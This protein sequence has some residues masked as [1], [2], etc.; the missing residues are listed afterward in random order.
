M[1]LALIPCKVCDFIVCKCPKP[2]LIETVEIKETDEWGEKE[3]E[4]VKEGE[5]KI[6]PP[7]LL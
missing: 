1:H 7:T 3:K 5:V 6:N 2:R 4:K